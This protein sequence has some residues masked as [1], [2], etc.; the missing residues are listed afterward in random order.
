MSLALVSGEMHGFIALL[1]MSN[2]EGLEEVKIL[3][4]YSAMTFHFFIFFKA[5]VPELS[6]MIVILF[7]ALRPFVV[8]WKKL[9]FFSP[10]ESQSNLMRCFQNPSSAL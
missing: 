10:R 4:K 9:V 1:T 7:L 3:L 8:V 2:A 6:S 5:W